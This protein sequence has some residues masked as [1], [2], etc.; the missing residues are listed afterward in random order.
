M[1]GRKAKAGAVEVEFITTC[2]P[3]FIFN[4]RPV[5]GY[6][7]YFIDSNKLML[8]QPKQQKYHTRIPE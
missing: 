1:K 6:I 5:E 7:N 4:V 2:S 8:Y 3:V